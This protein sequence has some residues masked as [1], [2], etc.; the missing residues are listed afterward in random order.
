MNKELTLEDLNE[1][2]NDVNNRVT[3]LIDLLKLRLPELKD[4]L[5][6]L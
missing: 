2:I 5:T 1:K 3:Y 4:K 6:Y